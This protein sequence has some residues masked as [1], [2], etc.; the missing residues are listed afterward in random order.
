MTRKNNL[1]PDNKILSF[2]PE[3]AKNLVEV[4]KFQ[5]GDHIGSMI[6]EFKLNM[7]HMVRFIPLAKYCQR[8]RGALKLSLKEIGAK[9][10]VPKYKLQAIEDTSLN[11][12]KH[13]ILIKYI[14]FLGIERNLNCGHRKI[15]IS[16]KQ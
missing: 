7:D 12:V 16:L 15:V 10:K 3:Q 2:N 13:D 9:L 14:K 4:A 8:K 11:Q 5:L 6:S 1:Q